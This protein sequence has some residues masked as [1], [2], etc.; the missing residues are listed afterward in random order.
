MEPEIKVLTRSK[1]GTLTGTLSGFAAYYN[2]N[3]G[4]LQFVFVI[5]ALMSG[6]GIVL[7]LVLWMSIPPYANRAM[8]LQR[9]KQ[10]AKNP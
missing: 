4:G 9:K 2:L 5:A 6:F 10:Q 1:N 7:Y 3:L 8:L